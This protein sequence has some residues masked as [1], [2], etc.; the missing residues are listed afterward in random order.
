MRKRDACYIFLK[1][2]KE[3]GKAINITVIT[4][5]SSDDRVTVSNQ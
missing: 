3:G 5:Q 2:I 1:I 4:A